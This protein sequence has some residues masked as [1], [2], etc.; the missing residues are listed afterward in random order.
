MAFNSQTVGAGNEPILN[1]GIQSSETQMS[2]LAMLIS[3]SGKA[4]VKF[5]AGVRALQEARMMSTLSNMSDYQLT[6]IGIKRSEIPQYA[7]KLM[8]KS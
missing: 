4:I 2:F 8:I 1:A 5:G 6:Q 3:W 7:E